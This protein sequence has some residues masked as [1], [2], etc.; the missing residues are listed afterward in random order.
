MPPALVQ[1][2]FQ[3]SLLEN[4]TPTNAVLPTC[5]VYLPCQL[6]LNKKICWILILTLITMIILT[7]V[8][9]HT[10]CHFKPPFGKQD[11]SFVSPE[12]NLTWKELLVYG[13][14][15][16]F[17]VRSFVESTKS[18]LYLLG[19]ALPP[20]LAQKLQLTDHLF[21]GAYNPLYPQ[22]TSL[23]HPVTHARCRFVIRDEERPS[24][25]IKAPNVYIY[26]YIRIQDK[27]K[28]THLSY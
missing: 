5:D 26:T 25:P 22:N 17:T 4:P 27:I 23:I 16:R 20:V 2:C 6:L 10:H 1:E 12:R 14:S 19:W 3:Q 18:R 21:L 15:I 8:A 28:L 11:E 7:A 24:S 13:T 9:S